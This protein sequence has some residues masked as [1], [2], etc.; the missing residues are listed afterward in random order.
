MRYAPP[1]KIRLQMNIMILVARSIFLETFEEKRGFWLE[2]ITASSLLGL[3]SAMK[4]MFHR[5]VPNPKKTRLIAVHM[6]FMLEK[7]D[8][9]RFNVGIMATV[10]HETGTIK[11]KMTKVMREKLI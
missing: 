11:V 2:S 3:T 6:L 1:I 4:D 8:Q 7:C 9:I 5:I 10:M